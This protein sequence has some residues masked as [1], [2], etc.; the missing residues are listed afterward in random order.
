MFQ[1]RS[2]TTW[3]R[4]S[5]EGG[6]SNNPDSSFNVFSALSPG[7]RTHSP[8]YIDGAER[9]TVSRTGPPA[10]PPDTP[11]QRRTEARALSGTAGEDGTPEP[12]PPPGVSRQAP[13]RPRPAAPERGTRRSSARLGTARPTPHAGTRLPRARPA[14]QA[15]PPSPGQ[16]R[17]A[18]CRGS[19]GHPARPPPRPLASPREWFAALP[20][21][22][23]LRE[24]RHRHPAAAA[25]AAARPARPQPP[26]RDGGSRRRRHAPP[27]PSRRSASL[28]TAAPPRLA[29][30]ARGEEAGRGGFCA[31]AAGTAPGMGRCVERAC[32][33]RG[34]G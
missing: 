34:V 5:S 28:R 6:L 8:K 22:E 15:R 27:F 1:T 14:R 7:K 18:A 13:P 9:Q 11:V 3:D 10:V 31:G 17:S 29:A 16:P 33:E 32:A 26:R 19:G 24:V 23:A 30:H 2:T 4:P 20:Y 12:G 21:P 25:P